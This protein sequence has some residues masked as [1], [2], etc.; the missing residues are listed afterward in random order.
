MVPL[1]VPCTWWILDGHLVGYLMETMTLLMEPLS[2][3][4]KTLK[5]PCLQLEEI[6][7]TLLGAPLHSRVMICVVQALIVPGTNLCTNQ[8]MMLDIYIWGLTL[9]GASVDI[10]SKEVAL[11]YIWKDVDKSFE[12]P[13]KCDKEPR[14]APCGHSKRKIPKWHDASMKQ[15]CLVVA[16]HKLNMASM[17][18]IIDVKDVKGQV[19]PW[20]ASN[21]PID[22]RLWVDP[23]GSA[24]D[25]LEIYK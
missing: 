13:W 17:V 12:D 20:D 10:I 4:K 14:S 16:P 15:T 8:M 5:I 6:T 18:P 9:D 3:W 2:R 19:K 11:K 1:H 21:N 22:E 24:T 25:S 23:Q 7:N